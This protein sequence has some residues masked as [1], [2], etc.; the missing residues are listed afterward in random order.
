[1]WRD[2]H[3]AFVWSTTERIWFYC[4][5]QTSHYNSLGH[6]S[7]GKV[8]SGAE[9]FYILMKESFHAVF[10]SSPYQSDICERHRFLSHGVTVLDFQKWNTIT[11]Q[12]SSED[13]QSGF[14]TLSCRLKI[15]STRKWWSKTICVTFQLQNSADRS[16]SSKTHTQT[17]LSGPIFWFVTTLFSS[18][19]LQLDLWDSLEGIT[20]NL[21]GFSCQKQ[22]EGAQRNGKWDAFWDFCI[23]KTNVKHW[24][25]RKNKRWSDAGVHWTKHQK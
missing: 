21:H 7:A 24:K 25:V 22:L 4:L 5:I 2:V 8:I 3:Q 23:L 13:S 11:L 19:T 12:Q 18:D 14:L 16:Q 20:E 15:K 6:I 1:M 9:G 17:R 10:K